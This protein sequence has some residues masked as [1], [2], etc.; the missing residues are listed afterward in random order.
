MGSLTKLRERYINYVNREVQN[1][2]AAIGH[3]GTEIFWD[4][5]YIIYI[6]K[7]T[8][9]LTFNQLSGGQKVLYA[10]MVRLAINKLF[11][12][13]FGLF[14]LDEPTIHLDE[15]SRRILSN[16][17]DQME[18]IKQLIIVSH[19]DE[20]LGTID[21][22]IELKQTEYKTINAQNDRNALDD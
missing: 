7:A 11:S 4:P 22:E 10:L 21:N 1:I 16:F 5:T 13:R 12:R 6:R 18:G 20:F 9:L 14:I 19:T 8:T 17:I 2:N 3:P 15:D